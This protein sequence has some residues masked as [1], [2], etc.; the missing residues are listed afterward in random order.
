MRSIRF[1]MPGAI[2]IS[3]PALTARTIRRNPKENRLCD[4][5]VTALPAESSA[6]CR[7]SGTDL[8]LSRQP[9]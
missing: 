1:I 5:A 3:L 7:I 9:H 8:P 2:A 6:E 4:E